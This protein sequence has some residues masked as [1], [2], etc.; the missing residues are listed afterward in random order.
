MNIRQRILV[1]FSI[2]L[3][4]GTSIAVLAIITLF[5]N[6]RSEEFK[7]S[8]NKRTIYTFTLM[9]ESNKSKHLTFCTTNQLQI[10]P[11]SKTKSLTFNPQN[12]DKYDISLDLKT[13]ISN[14]NLFTMK[15]WA[16]SQESCFYSEKYFDKK[17]QR[18]KDVSAK[19]LCS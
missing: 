16:M 4:T 17:I 3:K 9:E 6:Y 14:L 15:I 8:I 7:K 13:P 18:G 12:Q 11:L 19:Y 5:S 10:N 1:R 2:L